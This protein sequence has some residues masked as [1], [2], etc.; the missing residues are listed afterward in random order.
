MGEPLR[1]ILDDAIARGLCSA[2]AIAVGDGGREVLV[3]GLGRSY[4]VPTAGPIVDDLAT[5]D[6]ASVSKVMATTA[7]A[8]ALVSRGRLALD[9][10]VR[11]LAGLAVDS[12]ITVLHLLGHGAGYPAHVKFYERFW[13]GELAGEPDWRRTV[14]ELAATHPLERAPGEEVVYSDLGYL[15]LGATLEAA[16]GARLDELFRDLVAAP[17]G[18][19]AAR[20]VD[21]AVP[22]GE[23][24]PFAGGVVATEVCARR[25][26][27]LG[28]VHDENAHVSGGVAGHAGLFAPVRDVSRFGQ[29]MIELLDGRDTGG[30]S[31]AVAREF[32]DTAAAPG[33]TRRLGWDTP[34]SEPGVSHAG[35]RWPRRGAFGHLGFTGTSLWLDVPRRRWVALLTNRVHPS[36]EGERAAAIKDL[37]RGVMD[38]VVAMLEP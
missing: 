30:I 36:R 25:G 13:S 2:A 20:Y 33:H 28:E 14:V 5:Y 35:D 6:L 4:T 27:V 3:D 18:L 31:A 9:Q 16:G 10:Q 24:A 21:L 8:M 12:R 15:T 19:G 26:L 17:L 23:R 22:A 34:S 1:R 38:A 7:V 11:E 29:A 37:R 32:V